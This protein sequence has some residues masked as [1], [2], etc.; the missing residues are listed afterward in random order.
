MA[1]F[2][3]WMSPPARTSRITSWFVFAVLISPLL[4]GAALTNGG[5]VVL[6]LLSVLW[7]TSVV[8]DNRRLRRLAGDRVGEDIG[9]FARAFD[10]RREPFDPRVVRAVWDALQPYVAFSGGSV[11]LRPTDRIDE[12]LNIDADDIDMGVLQ[13]IAERVGRTLENV[14]ANSIYGHVAT[15]GD[16]VRL[17]SA[18][19]SRAAA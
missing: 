8:T 3:R 15:V 13:E 17:V 14:E 2:S 19:P 16:L 7:T 9:T 11:P 6:G 12:D 5:K 1:T 4:V 18:Q 10:R